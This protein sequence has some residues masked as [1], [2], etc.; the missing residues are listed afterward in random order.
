[1]PRAGLALEAVPDGVLDQRLE[2]EERHRHRQHLRRDLQRDLQPVAEPGPLEQQV[3]VDRAQLLG[4]RGEVA[5][6]PERVAGE[7][8]ELQQQVAGPLGSVR[9]NEAIAVSEL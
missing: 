8:G 3:A 7:V 9:T 1:M 4:Q 5:V 6:P 2:A